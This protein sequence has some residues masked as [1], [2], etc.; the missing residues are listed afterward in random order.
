M[1]IPNLDLAVVSAEIFR[2]LK[3]GGIFSCSEYLLTPDMDFEDAKHVELHEWFLPTLAA[4]QSNYPSEVTDALKKAGFEIVLSAPSEAP[5]WPLT[6]QKT[7]LFLAMRAV[8]R[9]LVRIG[10]VP[11]YA[12]ILISNLLRGGVA[13]ADAEKAKLADLNWRIIARKP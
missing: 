9:G 2:T 5:A 8:V 6:D 11:H 1:I 4:T 7:D 3:P 13:W 12:D 10:L